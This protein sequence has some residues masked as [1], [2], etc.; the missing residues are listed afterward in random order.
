MRCVSVCL[1]LA[2]LAVSG[3]VQAEA[4]P[5]VEIDWQGPEDCAR[6]DAVRAKVARLLGGSARA[7]GEA[8]QVSVK[9][10]R[11]PGRYVAVLETASTAGA[12]KKRLEGESCDAIAL[13]S[14]VVIALA[15]DPEASLDEE[16]PT[17]APPEPKPAPRAPPPKL[18]APRKPPAPRDVRPYLHASVGV[19]F[20]LL[21]EPSGFTGAGVGVRYRRLSLE[22]AGAVYQPR[23]VTRE[24]RP[25]LGAD[26]RLVTADLLG[27]YVV[28]PFELGALEACPGIRLEY[29]GASAL[30]ATNPDEASVLI[31][32]FVLAGR[33]RLRATS[34]LSALLDLGLAARPFQPRFVLLGVGEVHEI[35]AIS[36]F[37]RTGLLLEF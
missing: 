17:A 35:P 32:S 2:L 11:E 31:G 12:G 1:G 34:W 19:L 6:G 16:E 37:A 33:G 9:V 29:L 21:K 28:V 3:A 13:A 5:F 14:A 10:R 22:V 7:A 26:L 4:S 25:K 23:G 20:H 24:D 36:A 30:G 15:I 8:T 27:C 18:T